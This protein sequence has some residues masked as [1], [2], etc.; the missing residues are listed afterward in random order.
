MGE[1]ICRKLAVL[2]GLGEDTWLVREM[3]SL[4]QQR[5]RGRLEGHRILYF[6]KDRKEASAQDSFPWA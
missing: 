1:R 2:I 6:T 3:L 4:S 5:H